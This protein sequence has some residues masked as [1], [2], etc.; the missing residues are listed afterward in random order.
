MADAKKGAPKKGKG[1]SQSSYYKAEGE[2]LV[3]SRKFCP[4]CGPGFF[5]GEH[6]NRVT[7]GRC[8]YT[9]FGKK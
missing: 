5:L 7:C 3:R 8:H 6:G 2:K 9:E 4:K 1:K